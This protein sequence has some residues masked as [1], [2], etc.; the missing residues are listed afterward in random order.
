MVSKN[1]TLNEIHWTQTVG[2]ALQQ[3]AIAANA[4]LPIAMLNSLREAVM[5]RVE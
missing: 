3:T 2:S 5:Q 1:L 4:V